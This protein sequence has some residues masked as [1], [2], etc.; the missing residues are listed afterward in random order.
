M[1]YRLALFKSF[2]KPSMMHRCCLLVEDDPEDQ[3]FFMDT[4]HTVTGDTGC[5]AVGNG[6]EALAVLSDE[7]ISPDI[8][9]TDLNMP[10]LDGFA[11]VE[12]LRKNKKFAH[13]PVVIYTS[14]FSESDIEKARRLSV[15]AIYSKT[16]MGALK[17]ILLRHFS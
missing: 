15:T 6:E 16:R 11:F 9:F 10:K 5:Y 12:R 2:S 3:E 17:D 4:L 13:I 1:Q 14:H 8:I 7:G